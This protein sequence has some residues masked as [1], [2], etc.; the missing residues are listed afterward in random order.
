MDA[1]VSDERTS[2]I[3]AVLPNKEFIIRVKF[4][5]QRAD[6]NWVIEDK[7]DPVH[8]ERKKGQSIIEISQNTMPG[9]L[10]EIDSVFYQNAYSV[11]AVVYGFY[12]VRDPDPANLVT[13]GDGDLNCVTQRVPE[14]FEDALRIRA[15]TLMVH[16]GR[17]SG[18]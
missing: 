4:I 7:I 5:K 10:T 11:T 1:Y 2:W 12:P 18:L 13:L 6:G 8:T 9:A 14:H 17:A 3:L 16:E 15:N